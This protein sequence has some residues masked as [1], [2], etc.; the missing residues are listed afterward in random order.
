MNVNDFLSALGAEFFA[1]IPDSKLRPRVDDLRNQGRK[2][3]ES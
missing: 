3:I 1:G 2:D